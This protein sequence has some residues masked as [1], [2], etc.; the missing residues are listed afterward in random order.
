MCSSYLL[1]EKDMYFKDL[2]KSCPDKIMAK[3]GHKMAEQE[4]IISLVTEII[5]L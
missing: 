1:I 2:I 4:E 5:S 3:I